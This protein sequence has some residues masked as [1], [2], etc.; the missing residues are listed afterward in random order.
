MKILLIDYAR[1]TNI[2]GSAKYNYKLAKLFVSLNCKVTHFNIG[3]SKNILRDEPI[4]EV[5]QIDAIYNKRY[6]NTGG[7]IKA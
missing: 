4:K 3:L 2:D 5:I 7:F 6:Q 1:Y